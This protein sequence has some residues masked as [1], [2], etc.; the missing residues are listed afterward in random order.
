MKSRV[1]VLAVLAAGLWTVAGPHAQ[2]QTK[3]STN[4]KA[5]VSGGKVE[6]QLEAGNYAV[7]AA[8]DNHIRVALNGNP[9]NARV[10]LTISGTQAS[11][12]VK[13]T[14]RNNFEA[15]IEVPK[16]THLVVRLSAGNLT[17]APIVGNKDIQSTAGNVEIGVGPRD[18]YS[19]VDTSVKVGDI[20]ASV[21][22]GSKSGLFPHFTWTGSGKYT[23]R[24]SLGAGNLTLRDK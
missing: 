21:F 4:D 2:M 1:T 20:N 6:M 8:A 23:L 9:G 7:R 17:I 16:A 10:E 5:F 14:P 19:N 18:D 11:L 24:A 15:T 3:A 12:A 22:G 13:D